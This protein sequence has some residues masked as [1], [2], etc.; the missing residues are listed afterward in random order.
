[1]MIWI[2]FKIKEY[3][4]MRQFL[5][6]LISLIGFLCNAQ[7]ISYSYNDEKFTKNDS[8]IMGISLGFDN[9]NHSI[10]FNEGFKN[11]YLVV[12]VKRKIIYEGLITTDESLG[13]ARGVQFPKEMKRLKIYINDKKL[14]I[15]NRKEYRF[16]EIDKVKENYKI[17]YRKRPISYLYLIFFKKKCPLRIQW[18]FTFLI[19]FGF[20]I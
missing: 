10:G 15:K 1:M 6:L 14:K 9:T 13:V 4:I 16:I 19:S 3:L 7:E 8:L 20:K 12:K 11:D 5:F 18:A 2:G 17:E